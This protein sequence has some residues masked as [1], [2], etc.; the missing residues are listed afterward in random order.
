M[1]VTEFSLFSGTGA[2]SLGLRI[3]ADIRTVGYCEWD[4]YAASVILAR[5]EDETLDRAPV[6]CGDL[7]E[8][9][10]SPFLGVDLVTASPPCQPYSVA[11]ARRGNAD[12]R[13]HGDGDGPIP[14]LLRIIGEVRPRFVFF[15]NV[16]TW[17]TGGYFQSVRERLLYMGYGV[18]RPLFL[19]A[20]D[21]GAPHKRE[22]VFVLAHAGSERRP[23]ITGSASADEN[24]HERRTTNA[25][26]E[27][28]C[29]V[30]DMANPD[31]AAR[32]Q[33][34]QKRGP[35]GR[36]AAGQSREAV[37][38]AAD[39]KSER[40]KNRQRTMQPRRTNT[41]LSSTGECVADGVGHGLQR[42]D[43]LRSAQTAERTEA[44]SIHLPLFPPGPEE[45]DRWR[46]IVAEHQTLEP[47]LC[48]MAHAMAYRMDRLRCTGNGVVPLV[49]AVA[50]TILSS[51]E[52]E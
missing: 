36:T 6:W 16:P 48:G 7:A 27:S 50:W 49:V 35:E 33:D 34:Q 2:L 46:D 12:H 23:E 20:E 9:D 11:G 42:R 17:I 14:H 1:V 8:L 44:R 18:K 4:A 15:E 22:R 21:V 13:S 5:M 37:G 19:A 32:R 29:G 10:A 43:D 38:N 40:H 25:A 47:A 41:H 3:A 52:W 39:A 51:D 24:Q 26:N 28:Q 30:Q 31:A 45:Y